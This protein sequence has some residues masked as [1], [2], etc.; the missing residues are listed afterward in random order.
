MPLT[1]CY[2]CE[3]EIP[4]A[5]VNYQ[6]INGRLVCGSQSCRHFLLRE[7]GVPKSLFLAQLEIQRASHRETR[8]K[9]MDN[10][11]KQQQRVEQE[12]VENLKLLQSLPEYA[13]T[14]SKTSTPIVTLPNA[15]TQCEPLSQARR[16]D[17]L[18][19]LRQVISE[20]MTFSNASEISED[21]NLDAS[22]LLQQRLAQNNDEATQH[23]CSQVCA[24]CKGYCCAS[25][26]NHGFISA[27][28]IRKLLDQHPE[29][30]VNEVLNMYLACLPTASI[31]HSCINH[32]A[33]GCALSREMRS[34]ICNNYLCDTVLACE[35][36]FLQ[37][38]VEE[39]FA[40]KRAQLN[41]ADSPNAENSRVVDY[42]LI[43]PSKLR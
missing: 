38:G 18:Q 43:Y 3:I 24:L 7:A 36:A 21:R 13:D 41:D 9:E 16:D 8:R 22:N 30:G 20:A 35:A 40:V 17:Y 15:N 11:R 34:D 26:K 28:T 37:Q 42:Q 6:Q 5:Q 4:P 31:E 33:K 32:T 39:V 19:H 1:Q 14:T 2:V 12:A 10:K 23:L 27:L 29:L 25:G